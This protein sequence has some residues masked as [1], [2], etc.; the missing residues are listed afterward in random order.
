MREIGVAAGGHALGLVAPKLAVAMFAPRSVREQAEQFAR[1]LRP[2]RA[3][4]SISRALSSIESRAI[5][6]SRQPGSTLKLTI[7]TPMRREPRLDDAQQRLAQRLGNPGID[8]VAD[9][10]VEFALRR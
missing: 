1:L 8:A 7:A 9:D 5:W 6:N 4:S 10:E 3:G 2:A